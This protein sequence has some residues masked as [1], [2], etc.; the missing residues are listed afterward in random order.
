MQIDAVNLQVFAGLFNCRFSI[1]ICDT[2]SDSDV[3]CYFV[4]IY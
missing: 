4:D 3:L 2:D 1:A